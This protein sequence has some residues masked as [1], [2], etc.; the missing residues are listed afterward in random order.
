MSTIV[1]NITKGE[2]KLKHSE[3][4]SQWNIIG[5][6]VGGRYKIAR[7]PYLVSDFDWINER[8][9]TEQLANAK[10][11]VDAGTTANLCGKLPSELLEMNNELLEGVSKALKYLDAF[12]KPTNFC[13]SNAKKTLFELIKK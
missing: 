6:M 10:L 2:W 12:E 3:N 5:S 13:I 11:I 1:E 4:N 7:C 9:K 8:E